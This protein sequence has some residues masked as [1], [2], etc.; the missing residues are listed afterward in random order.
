MGE[1]WKAR[2]KREAEELDRK[3]EEER[4]AAQFDFSA[5]PTFTS[6]VESLKANALQVRG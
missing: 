4:L 1:D 3:F 2:A 5:A 6:F